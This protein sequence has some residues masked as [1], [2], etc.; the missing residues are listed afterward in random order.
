MPCLPAGHGG[1]RRH[2]RLWAAPAAASRRWGR[3][4]RRP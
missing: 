4:P 1:P 3:V 2:R